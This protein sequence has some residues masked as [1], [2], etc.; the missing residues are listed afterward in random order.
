[1]YQTGFFLDYPPGYLYA[2]WAVGA[3]AQA[4]GASGDILR[5]IIAVPAQLAD[6]ALGL[7]TIAIVWRLTLTEFSAAPGRIQGLETR[8]PQVPTPRVGRADIR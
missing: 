6:F 1:M 8:V 4:V 3:L 5:L 7:L 2:L